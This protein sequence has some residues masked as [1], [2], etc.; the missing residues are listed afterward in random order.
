MSVVPPPQV[1]SGPRST[2]VT[3][4]GCGPVCGAAF[5]MVLHNFILRGNTYYFFL[6]YSSFLH[7]TGSY[8]VGS[9]FYDYFYHI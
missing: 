5:K 4:G 2:T 3:G 6:C 8:S 1:G 7:H 9:V